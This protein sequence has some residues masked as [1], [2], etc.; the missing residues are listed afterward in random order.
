[1]KE[2]PIL[3]SAPMV[4]A[5]LEGRKTM[6]R[7]VMKPVSSS[8]KFIFDNPA[9][10]RY[11]YTHM[12]TDLKDQYCAYFETGQTEES[13]YGFAES[14]ICPYGQPGDRMWVRER[15]NRIGLTPFSIYNADGEQTPGDNWVWK[16][17]SLPSIHCPRGLSR[18][19]LE[20]TNVRVERLNDIS[21]EDALAEGVIS[22]EEYDDRAGEENLWMCPECHGYRVH[23][24]LGKDFGMTEVDCT[25][26][27]T[28]KKRFCI[29][30]E[31]IN[32]PGS[33][34]ANPWV[35]VVE[36]K[37]VEANR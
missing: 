3:F 9:F 32:G 29:L 1:M 19:T 34:D 15:I 14:F 22:D 17:N 18:I 4:R 5:I 20:I 30:W 11:K 25:D 23:P 35:W 6:T 13:K 37:R 7:R 33:W 27:D 24:A 36:F 12:W 8:E 16:H 26:C 2:R 31:S 10:H 28:Q 21:E